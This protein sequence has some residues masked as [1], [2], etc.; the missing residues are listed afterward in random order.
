MHDIVDDL[1]RAEFVN[2]LKNES[3]ARLYSNLFYLS[4][5]III[6][7]VLFIVHLLISS[8]KSSKNDN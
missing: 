6:V 7:L 5:F 3:R 2:F 1:T 4:I 8:R